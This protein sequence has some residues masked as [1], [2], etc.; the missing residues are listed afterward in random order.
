MKADISQTP[1]MRRGAVR[2][3]ALPLA[4]ALVMALAAVL[5][6][7]GTASAHAS[8]V[9]STPAAN[10]VLKAAPTTITIHFAENVNPTGSDVVVL[11]S[12]GVTVS[13]GPAQVDTSDLKT[14]TVSMHGNDS[15]IYLVQWHTVSADDGDPDIGA[16]TFTVSASGTPA[17]TSP[18]AT[19]GPGS[20]AGGGSSGSGA[21]GAPG[22]VI[23][24]VGVL[25]L[26]VGLGGGV[27]ISRR[28]GR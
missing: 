28:A 17:A 18:T 25:G 21:S 7:A 11:D 5:A 20:T 8:Y 16:F 3:R 22:W 9:S 2:W 6:S 26:L 19:A 23:A 4:A 12:K 24:L 27:A 14:M 10:A 15:E 13:T 1:W